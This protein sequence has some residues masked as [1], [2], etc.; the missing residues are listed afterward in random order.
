[1][2]FYRYFLLLTT[3]ASK[4]ETLY[5]LEKFNHS[6]T[7][8]SILLKDLHQVQMMI[9]PF[10]NH[11]YIRPI[12]NLFANANLGSSSSPVFCIHCRYSTRQQRSFG[13]FHSEEIRI[14]V[15]RTGSVAFSV[16]AFCGYSTQ[17]RAMHRRCNTG[18]KLMLGSTCSRI[19]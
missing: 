19:S 8:R 10:C 2:M 9:R 3:P 15:S 17:V 14:N 16:V 7:L 6:R 18:H 1:M 5:L 11:T 4:L 13:I 12:V